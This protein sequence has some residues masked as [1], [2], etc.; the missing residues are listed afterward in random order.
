MLP[1]FTVQYDR[2]DY[3]HRSLHTVATQNSLE[4]VQFFFFA[5]KFQTKG[6]TTI[7]AFAIYVQYK[8]YIT[9]QKTARKKNFT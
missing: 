1:Y 8:H 5:L 6:S 9:N 7:A 2:Y 4:N 3:L